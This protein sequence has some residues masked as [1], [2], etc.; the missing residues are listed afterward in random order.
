[1]LPPSHQNRPTSPQPPQPQQQ[2]PQFQTMI[3]GRR[4]KE[5]DQLEPGTALIAPYNI[6]VIA[7]AR[8]GKTNMLLTIL[9]TQTQSF[10][11]VFCFTL[12]TDTRDRLREEAPGVIIFYGLEEWNDGKNLAN[13][14]DAMDALTNVSSEDRISVGL[15]LDDLLSDEGIGRHKIWTRLFTRMHHSGLTTFALMHGVKMLPPGARNNYQFVIAGLAKPEVVN[16]V[17]G[18]FFQQ[19]FPDKRDFDKL[20][21]QYVR[22]G[23]GL[24]ANLK[25]PKMFLFETEDPSVRPIKPFNMSSR[26]TWVAMQMFGKFKSSAQLPGGM[27]NMDLAFNASYQKFMGDMVDS[28]TGAPIATPNQGPTI[29]Y[30]V[31]AKGETFGV[32]SNH[33]AAS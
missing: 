1:M 16:D 7:Q 14:L 29:Q 24:A 32:K 21:S 17:Y 11:V 23:A 5:I 15:I 4:V 3:G 26:Q 33:R 22:K 20:Y 27:S 12:A 9:A 8:A 30:H 6:A 25:D 19:F 28:A 13:I 10:D 31:G 2:Q 18:M